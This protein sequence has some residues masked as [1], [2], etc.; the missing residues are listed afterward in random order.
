[1]KVLVASKRTQGMRN[2]D[3][4]FT[5]DGELVMRPP[6]SCDC[7]DCPC[8][9]EMIGVGSRAGTTTF[10]V[11]DRADLDV[12]TYRQMLRDELVACGWVLDE[13][14]ERWLADFADR[15]LTAAAR[16][17]VGDVLEI[18]D[19]RTVV[20]RIGSGQSAS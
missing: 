7:P 5:I 2:W 8:E 9:R 20:R 4:S 10:T 19:D 17:D 14:D 3:M 11:A 13:P 12:V 18:G 1:M 15:H 16:F 6:G